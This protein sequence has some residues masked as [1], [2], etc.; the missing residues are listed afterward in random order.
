MFAVFF[1]TLPRIMAN[2][3]LAMSHWQCHIGNVASRLKVSRIFIPVKF[4]GYT[5][6]H[7]HHE[8]QKYWPEVGC[9]YNLNLDSTNCLH[10]P[11]NPP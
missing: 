9:E 7:Y 5:K 1:R 4:L 6:S 10:A 11:M 8:E 3:T 2:V